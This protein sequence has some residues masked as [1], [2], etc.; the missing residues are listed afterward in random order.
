MSLESSR[1]TLSYDDGGLRMEQA[2]H[3]KTVI[4]KYEL[5]LSNFWAI[6]QMKQRRL[7]RQRRSFLRKES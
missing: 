5:H 7:G 2:A 4:R 3:G 1:T 6:R